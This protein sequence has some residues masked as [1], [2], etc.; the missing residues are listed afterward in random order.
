MREPRVVLVDS[1]PAQPAVDLDPMQAAAVSSDSGAQL[2]LGGPGSGKSLVLREAMIRHLEAGAP[3]RDILGLAPRQTAARRWRSDIAARTGR[4][5]PTITTLHSVALR[6]VVGDAAERLREPPRLLSV[7]DQVQIVRDVLADSEPGSWPQMLAEALTTRQFAEQVRDFFA[8]AGAAGWSPDRLAT[9]P[10]APAQWR[11][12]AAAWHR[13]LRV[14]ALAGAVDYT[15]L[16]DRAITVLRNRPAAAWR[17]VCVDDYVELDPLQ[18][19]LLAA[20]VPPDGTLVAAADPDQATDG[21]RGAAHGSLAAFPDTFRH[22]LAPI[23]LSGCHRFGPEVEAVRSRLVA[24]LPMAGLPAAAVRR[25]RAPR[26]ASGSTTADAV[27][28]PDLAAQCAGIA[29]ILRRFCTS[30]LGS[31][32]EPNWRDAAVLVRSSGQIDSIEQALIGAGVPVRAAAAGRWLADQPT[33]SLLV[34]GLNLALLH[35]AS[36]DPAAGLP[37]CAEPPLVRSLGRRQFGQRVVE[38]LA[39]PMA[40]VDPVQLRGLMQGLRRAEVARAAGDGRPARPSHEILLEC[41]ADGLLLDAAELRKYPAAR[42]VRAFLRRIEKAAQLIGSDADVVHPLWVLWSDNPAG[43]GTWARQLRAAALSGGPGAEQAHRDLDAALALFSQAQRSDARGGAQRVLDF[44]SALSGMRLPDDRFGQGR[45]ERNAVALTTVH[46]SKG[47]E[48]PLV[49][50]AGVQEG[51]WPADGGGPGLLGEERLTDAAPS[52]PGV[53]EGHVADERRLFHVACTRARQHLVVTAVAAGDRD[54]TGAQPSRFLADLG[55]AIRD[56]GVV[57]GNRL[58]PTGLVAQ[59][60]RCSADA[61]AADA[62]RGAAIARLA[63]LSADPDFPWADAGTWW[64]TNAV[65]ESALPMW[66]PEEPLALTVT[67][68]S[69]LTDCPRRWFLTRVLRAGRP[70]DLAT[71]VGRLVHRVSEAWANDEIARDMAS[72]QAVVERVWGSLPF[73]AEWHSAARRQEVVAALE[74]LLAWQQANA[75]RIAF[76]EQPFDVRIELPDGDAVVLRGKAD[77]AVRSEG[78]GLAVL[79]VKTT[80]SPPTRAGVERHIQLAGYQWAVAAGALAVDAGAAAR[81][82]ASSSPVAVLAPAGASAGAGLLLASVP[83]SSG[84]AEPKV[85]WQPP[86]AIDDAGSSTWFLAA[87]TAAAG[88]MRGERFPAIESSAC[89]TCPVSALCPAR[90]P[91][92]E[93]GR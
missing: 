56:G 19:R 6:L 61:T 39:S 58:S 3:A 79:D 29:Q 72:A 50:V 92:Q 49:V 54:P 57:R 76:A 26:Q 18:V 84:S 66:Q 28:F 62:L 91:G 55:V 63:G 27:T 33:V 60:R 10:A 87:V 4:E 1:R 21:F 80:K 89:R 85:M 22:A 11:P 44:L 81:Q 8:R 43:P 48:W 88:R 37:A 65:S 30:S 17:L 74:R 71:G 53:R 7:D 46:Q 52:A 90:S 69:E 82:G 32:G 41:L 77:L 78:S 67:G 20:L 12:L 70:A 13:Y 16:L 15:S 45:A 23:V 86:I 14:A 93:V 38:L 24:P 25:H 40:G 42:A 31:Q 47:L 51:I 9:Q 34:T 36:G 35:P 64:S 75:G 83:G 59:L 73:D 68:L 2:I 5:A